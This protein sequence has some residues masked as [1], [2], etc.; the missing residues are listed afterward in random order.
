[1]NVT[2][3]SDL[4]RMHMLHRQAI[5]TRNGLDRAGTELTTGLKSDRFNA[6]GGN[7][8]RLFTLERSLERN[9]A[10]RDIISLTEIKLDVM[11]EGLGRILKPAE[12]LAVDLPVAVSQGDM[13][14]AKTHAGA[15][16]R[17]FAD[18]VAV[19]NGAVSGQSLYAGT[20]TD[21]AALAPAADMLADLDALAAAAATPEDAIAAVE[22]Y[23]RRDPAPAG[24][25]HTSGYLGSATDLSAVEIGEGQRLDAGIRADKD[26][27]VAVLRAQAL[28]AVVA[29][30]AFEGDVDAQRT[31]LGEAGRQMLDAK[32]GILALRAE[33]GA[34]QFAVET[35]KA[36]R[37]AERGTLDIARAGIVATD[38]LEA[39][40]NYQALQV[41]LEAIY[42]VTSR[43]STLSFTN[44]MR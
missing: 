20:A 19:L 37:V 4:S 30:G 15:A 40:S 7:L 38:P 13:G 43:L 26:E 29:G 1:M 31:L 34:R 39:A 35:A 5:T 41:Q 6:T 16:R 36:E 9:T 17:A 12:A 23:F 18:T 8:T 44:F 25:F 33:V 21:R 28:A 22:G 2:G 32:E 11:Q 27:L 10:F 42:T 14:A 3:G 24:A